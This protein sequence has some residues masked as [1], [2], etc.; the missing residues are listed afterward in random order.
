MPQ[1]PIPYPQGRRNVSGPETGYPNLRDAHAARPYAASSDRSLFR[2]EYSGGREHYE[3]D[4]SDDD[5]DYSD[6]DDGVR[7]DVA[8]YGQNYGMNVV[9]GPPGGGR[10][11]KS[12]R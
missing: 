3:Q 8:P 4:N 6:Q 10:P 7:V 12:R 9:T 1:M 5:V 11:R 2:R